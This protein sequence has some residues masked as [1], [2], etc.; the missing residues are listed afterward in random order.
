MTEQTSTETQ[1]A[2]PFSTLMG[3]RPVLHEKLNTRFAELVTDVVATG[4]KRHAD[5]HAHRRT[6]RGRH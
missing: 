3:A 1:T 4:K 2:A 6:V 5:A